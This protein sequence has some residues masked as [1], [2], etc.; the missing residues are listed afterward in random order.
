MLLCVCVTCILL[1]V[2]ILSQHPECGLLTL[3]GATTENPSFALNKALLSRC[4]VLVFEKLTADDIRAVICYTSYCSCCGKL[5]TEV[6]KLTA[7]DICAVIVRIDHFVIA[8]VCDL[9]WRWSILDLNGFI[10]HKHT[11]THTHTHT[12][13]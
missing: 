2:L 10:A 6:G 13:T 1:K 12:Q 5:A 7:D 8:I 11:H 3:I 4:R 9:D